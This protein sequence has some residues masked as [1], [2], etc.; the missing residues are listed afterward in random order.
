MP[1]PY[2]EPATETAGQP[3]REAA[4]K[5]EGAPDL[6]SEQISVSEKKT[7]SPAKEKRSPAVSAA[8]ASATPAPSARA[9]NIDQERQLKVLV[10]LAFTQG[11]DKAVEAARATENAY[12]IDKLHD[13][14]VDE[15]AERLRTEG[16]LKEI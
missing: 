13:T 16:K 2:R 11:I 1:D 12:L 9:Q 14:L 15:L 5:I 10:D 3:S 4:P 6:T 7:E 8:A